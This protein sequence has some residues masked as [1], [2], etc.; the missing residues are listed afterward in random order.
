VWMRE[1]IGEKKG[2]QFLE[3]YERDRELCIEFSEILTNEIH[4]LY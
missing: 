2:D 4:I 1:K 3:I